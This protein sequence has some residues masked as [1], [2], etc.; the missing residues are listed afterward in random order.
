MKS[1]ATPKSIDLPAQ[2]LAAKAVPKA[3][4]VAHPAAPAAKTVA[5]KLRRL[6]RARAVNETDGTELVWIPGGTFLRGS[7]K[8]KGA[9]DERPQKRIHLDGYWIAR[10][11][12]T[13]GQYRKYCEATG[14][15]LKPPWGQGMHAEP[16]GDPDTYPALVNWYEAADYAAW[17]GAALPTEAQWEKAAR[18]TDGR[19]Y[20]WGNRWD[21]RKAVG[22]ERTVNEFSPGMRPVG[23]SPDGASPYGVE[24][25]AGNCWEWVADWYGHEYYRRAPDRNPPGPAKGTHK[26]LRGGDSLWDERFSRC[27]ARMVMPPHVRNWVKTGFRVAVP[28]EASTRPR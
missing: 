15:E 22:L 12:I 4:P 2:T 27:A 10:T 25:M 20:P 18:D 9:S 11:P 17:A 8:G 19:E 24:D 13:L 16:K 5:P 28:A 1:D 26:V 7:P 23:S 21:P 14:K 6:A 3:K